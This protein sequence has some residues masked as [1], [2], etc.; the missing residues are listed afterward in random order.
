VMARSYGPQISKKFRPIHV[1]GSASLVR[2]PSPQ[3]LLGRPPHKGSAG[4]KLAGLVVLLTVARCAG[5]DSRLLHS[6]VRSHR[7]GVLVRSE[8][9]PGSS[10][11]QSEEVRRHAAAVSVDAGGVFASVAGRAN[12]VEDRR[13]QAPAT[14][15]A[16]DA[17]YQ[18]V[19]DA[20][21]APATAPT[22]APTAAPATA[23]VAPKLHVI[24]LTWEGQKDLLY[25]YLLQSM[26]AAHNRPGARDI[27][28]SVM[29]HNT[30]DPTAQTA[31]MSSV[32]QAQ[33]LSSPNATVQMAP[34]ELKENGTWGY[35]ALDRALESLKQDATG[36]ADSDY[37]MFCDGDR[38][39]FPEMLETVLPDMRNGVDLIGLSFI[40]SARHAPPSGVRYKQCNFTQGT[41]DLGSVLFRLGAVRSSGLNFSQVPTPCM[42]LKHGNPYK[43]S[44]VDT[45]PW[46]SADWGFASRLLTKGASR[47]CVGKAALMEQH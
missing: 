45:R 24:G 3:T 20:T 13:A 27:I 47:N 34:W 25:P 18:D 22:T 1:G 14:A 41:V 36:A 11:V 10:A 42:D 30:G 43:C 35:V 16:A 44:A 5:E 40:C 33:A 7:P 29:V 26:L 39:Y 12:A 28:M 31:L 15:D 37:I 2:M 17:A 21:S 46:W 32:T 8:P 6:H 9:A 4:G 19:P 23:H 38:V